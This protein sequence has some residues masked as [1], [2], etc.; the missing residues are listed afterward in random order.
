MRSRR[1]RRIAPDAW[2][3]MLDHADVL[4][5]GSSC[6]LGWTASMRQAAP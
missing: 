6:S 3:R 2:K 5:S 1:D 4:G